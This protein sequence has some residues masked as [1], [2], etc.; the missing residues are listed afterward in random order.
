MHHL[1][2]AAVAA[3]AVATA[4]WG[5]A[6]LVLLDAALIAA[7]ACVALYVAVT[8]T[9]TAG[10]GAALRAREP[11]ESQA[12]PSA[13]AQRA[14]SDVAAVTRVAS[15]KERLLLYASVFGSGLQ[16]S[17][18]K[19]SVG[20]GEFRTQNTPTL[21]VA[22]DGAV[23]LDAESLHGPAA[24]D[25]G[26][27]GV[28]DFSVAFAVKHFSFQSWL[29]DAEAPSSTRAR[30]LS[31]H[32]IPVDTARSATS[33]LL[34][35]AFVHVP[36]APT[37][38]DGA[39]VVSNLHV[40]VSYS[41]KSQRSAPFSVD[42]SKPYLYVVTVKQN[43]AT[44]VVLS[45]ADLTHDTITLDE[46]VRLQTSETTAKLKT[47][48][49]A[50]ILVNG[51]ALLQMSLYSF[52]VFNEPLST[53]ASGALVSHATKMLNPTDPRCP[54][55]PSVCASVACAGVGDWS[56][57]A[58][59]LANS[60]CRRAAADWCKASPEEAACACWN[61]GS[62]G[63]DSDNCRTWRA[64]MQN[65]ASEAIN[66]GKLS[67]GDLARIKEANMLVTKESRD[68]MVKEALEKARKDFEV[69][70]KKDEMVRL[71][72]ESEAAAS[73][74]LTGGGA[75]P[76]AALPLQSAGPT[77][78]T[79]PPRAQKWAPPAPAQS[80]RVEKAGGP[81]AWLRNFFG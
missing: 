37:K 1:V 10:R 24:S 77:Q 26:L 34:Q 55:D 30:V 11:F 16:K 14:S 42:I 8:A 44:D 48:S 20:D 2:Y 60:S 53:S 67:S 3:V 49:N 4:F 68:K 80:E 15:K 58:Q 18:W 52:C 35:V 23:K 78:A 21:S 66:P 29:G 33:D 46:L 45:R 65:D 40:E 76:P 62:A 17:V 56:D 51:D 47:A 41:S 12:P 22:D 28:T 70:Q 31:M 57:P 19:A 75:P 59:L 74:V 36:D 5:T 61:P 25:L 39:G 71:K 6:P 79:A 38:H 81:I 7:A 69:K 43:M 64:Y 9:A 72:K 27:S 13:A 32:A 63:Y 54:Y 73:A 50:E